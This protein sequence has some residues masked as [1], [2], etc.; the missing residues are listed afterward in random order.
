[1]FGPT[2]P[3]NLKLHNLEISIKYRLLGKLPKCRKCDRS[4]M[5]VDP[6]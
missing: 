1:M 6:V 4:P 5:E 3:L 2:W